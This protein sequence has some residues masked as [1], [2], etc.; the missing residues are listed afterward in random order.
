MKAKMASILMI[1]I[2]VTIPAK[3]G[4]ADWWANGVHVTFI[5]MKVGNNFRFMV[6][7]PAGPCAANTFLVF[8]ARFFDSSVQADTVK[9]VYATILASKLTGQ[10]L[11]IS[12]DNTPVTGGCVVGMVNSH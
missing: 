9:T 12:G 5:E 7:K 11:D 1:A 4:I 3:A 6:D 8:D 10:T 2:L